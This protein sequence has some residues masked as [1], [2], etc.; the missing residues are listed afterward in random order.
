M[1]KK[2]FTIFV[3]YFFNNIIYWK[4]C[5]SSLLLSD[6]NRIDE[7]TIYVND[8][9]IGKIQEFELFN[10]IS[11]DKLEYVKVSTFIIIENFN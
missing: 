9:G 2:Q 11:F 7:E 3:D 10:Y 1:I 6:R 4:L 5:L 8:L